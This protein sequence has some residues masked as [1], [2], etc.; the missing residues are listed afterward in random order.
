MRAS[1]AGSPERVDAGDAAAGELDREPVASNGR[2]VKYHVRRAQSRHAAVERPERGAHG[3]AV[4]S[5]RRI[6][7]SERPGTSAPACGSA[8]GG[9]RGERESGNGATEEAAPHML[10]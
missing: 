9:R 6:P 1:R 4:I 10:V 2:Y 7:P 5:P 8:G 3:A